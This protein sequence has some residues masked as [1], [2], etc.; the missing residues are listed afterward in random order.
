MG[1]KWEACY[2]SFYIANK[3]SLRPVANENVQDYFEKD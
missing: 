2:P 3:V 1:A